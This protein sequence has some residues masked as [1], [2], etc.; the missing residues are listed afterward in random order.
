MNRD[1]GWTAPWVS[2]RVVLGAAVA[3]AG[4]LAAR[5]GADEPFDLE[6][7]GGRISWPRGGARAAIGKG[8][9]RANKREGDG[10][11]P[12]GTFRL[13][14]GFYRE[15]R[16][17]APKTALPMFPLRKTYEWVDDPRDP[18]YNH[19][20]ERPYPAHAEA[21]WRDDEV[22]DIVIVIDY[23]MNP[24]APGAGSA[25]F[26]HIARPLFTPTV[27]CVAVARE[28]LLFL[29]TKLGP[30]SRIAIEA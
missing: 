16:V 5:A 3:A 24:A 26:L 12:A 6:Y 2:R 9:V 7:R 27:G 30:K 18:N 4:S 13:P 22:Y 19:L 20:A 8:G 11:T 17:T 1:F 21:M 29:V 15:D 23:N 25:I 14:F 28:T 10:A